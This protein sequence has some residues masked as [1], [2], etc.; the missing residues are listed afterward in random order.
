MVKFNQLI[1]NE[2]LNIFDK[3][4]ILFFS[5]LPISILV[6]NAAI[7]LNILIISIIF[8]IYCLKFEFWTWLKSKMF[9]ALFFLYIFLII[10]STYSLFFIVENESGGL[11][12]SILF[13]KF[14]LLVF[15]FSTLVEKEKV[16]SKIKINWLIIILVVIIDIFYEKYFGKNIFGFKSPNPQR[17]ISFFKDEMVVGGY[18]L[19]FGFATVTYFLSQS[20]KNKSIL[21]FLIIFLII[22]VSIFLTGERSNFIKSAFLF[23]VIGIFL[24][25]KN[26]YISFKYL[27]PVFFLI[28]SS[29]V[30]LN[31]DIKDRYS[32]FFKRILV[33]EGNKTFL[34][35]FENIKYFAHFD[36]AIKIFKNHPITGVGN[37]N[38]RKECSKEIYFEEKIKFSAQRC[39]THPHQ[40][41]FEIL[42]E[43][44]I[45]GYFFITSFMIVFLFKN[46]RIFLNT[47]NISHL[48]NITYIL[49]FFTPLLP[50]AGIFSTFNGSI[51]WI[52]FSL[53]Y[54]TYKK[55][56]LNFR[57]KI[58]K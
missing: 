6:G 13:I 4:S 51:F 49:L 30:Y 28:I 48:S 54:L 53:T 23:I 46:I 31:D 39:S 19:C 36:T 17:I 9:L 12:R 21:F 37:K 18:I 32:V 55:E 52:I 24:N 16:L 38:F 20:K 2:G 57:K 22:P 11:V 8:L 3:A 33:V 7:N 10:N 45:I 41:H 40:I 50:G 15:A 14:I 26:F 43:L 5:L 29:F 47:H 27:I 58:L 1:N 34:E 56:Y 35:K 44:G 25:N 42:S